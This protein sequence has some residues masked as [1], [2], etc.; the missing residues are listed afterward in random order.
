MI[1]AQALYEGIKIGKQ[2]TGLITY[3]RTDSLN[4]A[5][6]AVDSARA[7]IAQNFGDQFLP[8]TLKVYSSKAKGAQEAHEAIR[9]VNIDLTPQE[10]EQYL[11]PEE[12]K[13]YTLI[14]KRFIACQ[15]QDAEFEQQSL[16]INSILSFSTTL[17]YP[18]SS[19]PR[20]VFINIQN[21]TLAASLK[22]RTRYVNKY[23]SLRTSILTWRSFKLKIRD[24]SATAPFVSYQTVLLGISWGL[25][26]D[27]DSFL[28]SSATFPFRS[29]GTPS[30]FLSV[31]PA[32]P[33]SMSTMI[34]FLTDSSLF[35]GVNSSF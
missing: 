7:Y 3:M 32:L 6:E 35:A 9:P 29:K 19:T 26:N 1:I 14:Y 15:M 4:L 27:L 16:L 13:L 28:A 10:A 24:R 23:S 21:L 33:D 18:P 34:L 30:F 2:A 20:R 31:F 12:L 22:K 25:K 11:K 5:S 17:P 8:E